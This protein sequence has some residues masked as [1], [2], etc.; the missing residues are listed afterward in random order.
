M[1]MRLLWAGPSLREQN[2]CCNLL[3]SRHV[4]QIIGRHRQLQRK[5]FLGTGVALG[6]EGRGGVGCRGLGGRQQQC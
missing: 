4:A 6:G 1:P 5:V 3:N 2:I